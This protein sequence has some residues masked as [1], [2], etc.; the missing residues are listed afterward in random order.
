MSCEL[1]RSS[2][3]IGPVLNSNCSRGVKRVYQNPMFNHAK[4]RPL[5]PPPNSKLPVEHPEFSPDPSCKPTLLFPEAHKKRKAKKAAPASSSKRSKRAKDSDSEDGD[6]D[7]EKKLTKGRV[8][9]PN[10]GRALTLD[11]ELKKVAKK[12]VAKAPVEDDPFC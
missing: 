2:F 4:N 10:F 7:L 6:E 8:K 12:A 11:A 3:L 9:Q 1:L 5:S